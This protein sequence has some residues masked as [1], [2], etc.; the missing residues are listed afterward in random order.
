MYAFTILVGSMALCLL[1]KATVPPVV[2][3]LRDFC[4]GYTPKYRKRLFS[5]TDVMEK[6]LKKNDID[7][8]ELMY[9]DETDTRILELYH[10]RLV[11]KIAMLNMCKLLSVAVCISLRNYIEPQKLDRYLKDNSNKVTALIKALQKT[12]IVGWMDISTRVIEHTTKKLTEY[13]ERCNREIRTVR[14]HAHQMP[15]V[16]QHPDIT[17]AEANL[18]GA[19]EDI[20]SPTRRHLE[21]LIGPE[22]RRRNIP[23][24]ANGEE[25]A[26]A[27]E[28]DSN[29]EGD[30]DDVLK[31]KDDVHPVEQAEQILKELIDSLFEE[32]IR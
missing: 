16:T 27:V 4:Y 25:T 11:G 28:E 12:G 9:D 20:P 17:E 29:A 30:M 23:D 24:S 3:S 15:V 32:L 2:K 26:E 31:T 10:N 13:Q 6:R 18:Q 22:L 21:S 5:N 14:L 8:V 19:L 7:F 1:V